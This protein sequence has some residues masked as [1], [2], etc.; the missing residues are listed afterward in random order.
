MPLLIGEDVRNWQLLNL[1]L[2]RKLE[3]AALSAELFSQAIACVDTAIW[4]AIGRCF[5]VSV[6]RLLGGVSDRREIISIGGYYEDGKT[7]DDLAREMQDLKDLGMSGCKVKVG[8]LTPE[9]D[10]KR[11]RI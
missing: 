2:R 1:K 8:G 3:T 6:C 7:L 11:V 4:D 5:D 10:A 9:E